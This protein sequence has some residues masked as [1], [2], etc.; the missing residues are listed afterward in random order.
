MDDLSLIS[1]INHEMRFESNEGLSLIE[2]YATCLK[3]YQRHDMFV[4]A[5]AYISVNYVKILLQYIDLEGLTKGL[6]RLIHSIEMENFPPISEE[7]AL[8]RKTNFI[9]I[10]LEIEKVFEIPEKIPEGFL[11]TAYPPLIPT[12]SKIPKILQIE[13]RIRDVK[14][15]ILLAREDEDSLFF[16]FSIDLLKYIFG[17]IKT[18]E[19]IEKEICL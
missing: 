9:K 2:K 12:R 7:R 1:K 13:K 5:C 6:I 11:K 3:K 17:R 15:L 4:E 8:Q 14:T 10:I 19:V 16:N 18:V